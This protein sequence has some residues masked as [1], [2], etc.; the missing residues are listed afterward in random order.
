M[1]HEHL[2]GIPLQNSG[3]VLSSAFRIQNL[4]RDT[5]HHMIQLTVERGQQKLSQ[6]LKYDFNKKCNF[7]LFYLSGIHS[8]T[9]KYWG[10][11]RRE[12]ESQLYSSAPGL[13]FTFLFIPT[14]NFFYQLLPSYHVGSLQFPKPVGLVASS[15]YDTLGYQLLKKVQVSQ[16]LRGHQ[17]TEN[18]LEIIKMS[19]MAENVIAW[20]ELSLMHPF[21][22]DLSYTVDYAGLPVS[23]TNIQSQE[24]TYYQEN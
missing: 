21:P 4:H 8:P 20:D 18:T 5:I 10:G 6:Y 13:F 3:T 14:D 23:N 19:Q 15:F 12:E 2:C 16:R 7:L 24:I 22:I 17:P 9:F 11:R 1:I